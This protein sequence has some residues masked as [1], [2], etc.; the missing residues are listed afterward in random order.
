MLAIL[1]EYTRLRTDLEMMSKQLTLTLSERQIQDLCDTIGN[2]C[3]QVQAEHDRL[4]AEVQRVTRSVQ[5][6]KASTEARSPL[7]AQHSLRLLRDRAVR[8]LAELTIGVDQCVHGDGSWCDVL[9]KEMAPEISLQD[10][11]ASSRRRGSI[12]QLR[13]NVDLEQVEAEGG[14]SSEPTQGAEEERAVGGSPTELPRPPGQ[15]DIGEWTKNAAARAN[16]RKHEQKNRVRGEGGHRGV[17]QVTESEETH[18]PVLLFPVQRATSPVPPLRLHLL[19]ADPR[20]HNT[21]DKG[22]VAESAVGELGT[23]TGIGDS[24]RGEA[25]EVAWGGGGLVINPDMA[26]QYLPR[27]MKKACKEPSTPVVSIGPSA[28]NSSSGQYVLSDIAAGYLDI[29]SAESASCDGAVTPASA[30]EREALKHK[31]STG[32]RIFN[33]FHS[34]FDK[35]SFSGFIS[36]SLDKTV[37]PSPPIKASDWNR[38]HSMMC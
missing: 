31:S 6:G 13:T 14:E 26:P 9:P 33:R 4:E 24:G 36:T 37:P 35:W 8:R 15:H 16:A 1:R 11:C 21:Q 28:G 2:E 27:C 25:V 17:E 30:N 32:M 5:D 7:E 3:L 22:V 38:A 34:A 10:R 18:P 12:S 20:V 29:G 23:G 19:G